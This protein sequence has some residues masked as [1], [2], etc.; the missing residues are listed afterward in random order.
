VLMST[1]ILLL[2][3]VIARS[4][5]RTASGMIR[6]AVLV[7]LGLSMI[8]LIIS[9]Y[10]DLPAPPLITAIGSLTYIGLKIFRLI[11]S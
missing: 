8:S 1:S 5:A 11:K 3:A 9:F 4:F 10:C 7:S 6:Y 2:P